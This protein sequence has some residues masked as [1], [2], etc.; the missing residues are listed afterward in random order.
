MSE[1]TNLNVYGGQVAIPTILFFIFLVL[2]YATLSW[3]CHHELLP[4][5]LITGIASFLAY[6]MFTVAHEA[7]HGNISGGNEALKNWESG[8]GWIA[9]SCLFFPYSAFVLIHLEHHAH[10]NDPEQDPDHYVKGNN[11]VEVFF[12]CLTVVAYY[13]VRAIGSKG[14]NHIAMRKARS[15]AIFFLIFLL[16]ISVVVVAVGFGSA[17]L[18]VFLLPA[19]IIAPFLGFTFDWLPHYPHHNMDRDYNTRIVTVPGLEFLSLFQSYHLIHHLYPRVPFYKYKAKFKAIENE[20]L[21]HKAPIEGFRVSDGK[22][23]DP[24]NT[25]VDLIEG[26][27]WKYAL[28]VAEVT[29]L[30]HD[31]AAIRFKNPGGLAFRFRAGQ[32]VVITMLVAHKAVSRC[33]SICSNPES[34]ELTIGVKRVAN[35]VLSN[36]LLDTVKVGKSLHVAGPFGEFGLAP[37]E[38]SKDRAH[39]FIA[40]GSGITPLLSMIQEAIEQGRTKLKLIYGC[41]SDKDVMFKTEL[42]QLADK[43]PDQFSL[44]ITYALL[45]KQTQGSLLSEEDFQGY[46]YL[47]G[48]AAMME[49]S[50]AVLAERDV[51]VNHIITEKFEVNPVE[52]DG[53]IHSVVANHSQFEAYESETILEASIRKEEPLPHA[54]K[55]GQCGTC[56]VKLISGE[57]KWRKNQQNVLLENEI[58]AGY[59]LTCSCYCVNDIEIQ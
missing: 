8:M 30:T 38:T 27:S 9:A 55:M 17:F 48:P 24:E 12:R 20:L 3:M 19:L 56:K 10:T 15:Q 26:K 51:A 25:Y 49:A 29:H 1:S 2:G 31:S 44:H 53:P 57:V 22:L 11:A 45:D 16:L 46:F 43:Y 39:I 58:N 34:G 23:F 7:S 47:C 18:F 4:L 42:E 13:Y 33:Y 35:G 54:C 59:I 41:R 50:M 36:A 28:E 6:G 21:D 32:Y 37:I 52:L 14:G 40:G 5:W